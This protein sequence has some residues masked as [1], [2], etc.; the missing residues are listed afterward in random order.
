[1]IQNTNE[2]VR[3]TKTDTYTRTDE[4]VVNDLKSSSGPTAFNNKIKTESLSAKEPNG[5]TNNS[6]FYNIYNET[7]SNPNNKSNIL[8]SESNMNNFNNNNNDNHNNKDKDHKKLNNDYASKNQILN[9]NKNIEI[10]DNITKE[11]NGYDYCVTEANVNQTETDHQNNILITEASEL[12]SQENNNKNNERIPKYSETVMSHGNNTNSDNN[13]KNIHDQKPKQATDFKENPNQFTNKQEDKYA[14][15]EYLLTEINN[16]ATSQGNNDTLNKDSENE[17]NKINVNNFTRQSKEKTNKEIVDYSNYV[18]A[19]DVDEASISKVEKNQNNI[20]K[21]SNNENEESKFNNIDVKISSDYYHNFNARGITENNKI[22]NSNLTHKSPMC[23][24]YID[25]NNNKIDKAH[26][27]SKSPEIKKNVIINK[28]NYYSKS[29]NSN[30]NHNNNI[31]KN[32]KNGVM[33]TS[34][35]EN[36][37][38]SD[39]GIKKDANKVFGTNAIKNQYNQYLLSLIKTKAERLKKGF[40]NTS[41]SYEKSGDVFNRTFDN[42][43]TETSKSKSKEKSPVN[44]LNISI[45]KKKDVFNKTIAFG[46]ISNVNEINKIERKINLNKHQTNAAFSTKNSSKSRSKGRSNDNNDVNSSKVYKDITPKRGEFN[47]SDRFGKNDVNAG[48]YNFNSMLSKYKYAY[49]FL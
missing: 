16:V 40:F 22:E 13:N 42:K 17:N 48:G 12:I 5:E 21:L 41:V 36:T 15:S 25:K 44:K 37:L 38:Y 2:T 1:V 19:T 27:N 10:T 4:T 18:F 28:I 39:T 45:N 9:A 47:R 32:Y 29:K 11:N 14:V 8:S 24:N 7:T 26:Y 46:K 35:N 34:Y 20:N 23:S 43:I 30:D 33:N 31:N 49:K 3:I 6:D